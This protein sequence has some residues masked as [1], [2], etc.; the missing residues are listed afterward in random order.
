[1]IF[2]NMLALIFLSRVISRE[3]ED[4][5]SRLKNGEFETN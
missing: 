3:T 2:P 4:Y 1:M 5:Y